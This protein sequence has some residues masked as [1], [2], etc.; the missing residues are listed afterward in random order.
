MVLSLDP[1]S[2]KYWIRCR[3]DYS[4]KRLSCSAISKQRRKKTREIQA[5]VCQMWEQ[6]EEGAI[7]SEEL[8]HQTMDFV[9]F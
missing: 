7:T 1:A 9:K 8:L 6:F 2:V 5:K 4:C 3:S